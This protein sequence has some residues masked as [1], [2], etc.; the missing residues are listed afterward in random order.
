MFL[1]NKK[2]MS[3]KRQEALEVIQ[4]KAEMLLKEKDEQ[5]R[6]NEKMA[7]QEMMKVRNM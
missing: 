5:K 2:W 1:E 4:K 3:Q 6:G 7:I